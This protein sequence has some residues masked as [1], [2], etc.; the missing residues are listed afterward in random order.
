MKNSPFRAAGVCRST[1]FPLARKL[2]SFSLVT[3]RMNAGWINTGRMNTGWKNIGLMSI[4]LVGI[5]LIGIGLVASAV[6]QS[7]TQLPMQLQTQG[8]IKTI[9][10]I[11]FIVKENRTFNNYF[12]TFPGATGATSGPISTGKTIALGH[13][14]DQVRD[15][16]H[17]WPDALTAMNSGLMNQFD[18]VAFGNIN[19]DYRSMS[20]LL[21]S[22]IPNYW[23]YAQTFTLSDMSFSS[24]HGPSFPN[25]LYM[26][27]ADNSQVINN[28]N[29]PTHPVSP[30]WGCDATPG[31]TVQ[32][33]DVNGNLSNVFP[34]FDPQ[35]LGDLLEDAGISWRYYAPVQGTSGYIWNSYSAVNHIRN[36]PLWS[37]RVVPYGQFLT[38]VQNGT[39]PTVSWLI[40]DGADSE[41]PPSGTCA[42]ENWTVTQLNAL[43][44]SPYWSST[45]VFL[46]WD[47]FGGFYDP[48]YPPQPDYYGLGPR[49]PMLVISPYS[50]PGYVDHTPYNAA[51]VLKFIETRFGLP[52]LSARDSAAADMTAAFNFSQT[53]L[54]PLTLT[55]RTCPTGPVLSWENGKNMNFPSTTLGT[56]SSLTKKIYSLGDAPI[57]FDPSPWVSTLPDYTQTNTCPTTLN[58]KSNCSVTVTF[59]PQSAGTRNGK[60]EVFD[61]IS[62]SPQLLDLYAIG[63][64]ALSAV[65]SSLAFPITKMGQTKALSVTLTNTSSSK[66][67]GVSVTLS[68]SYFTETN[69]C[70]SSLAAGATC[71]ITVTF[72]PKDT[73]KHSANMSVYSSAVG[74]PLNVSMSG[75]GQ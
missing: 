6:A 35:T 68:S 2:I 8:D 34:C 17:S 73:K 13:T 64:S 26:I 1:W 74:S 28:P 10:H 32:I 12:G 31:S 19:G 59:N 45:A 44:N 30:S 25:H 41:H 62:T 40:P 56:T 20:Q 14:P 39:L 55:A 75:T 57:V 27:A 49:V 24:L 63:V 36:G 47:D 54:L 5:G 67:T 21:Q 53:P 37:S 72:T 23:R 48:V 61:N 7:P 50:K 42:G 38:D 60:Y 69:N 4:G 22:D 66:I 51:S 58:P 18:L 65:P 43:M 70:A 11:V 16:G 3:R 52:N 15:L 9:T 29:D 33:S 46:T 71:A